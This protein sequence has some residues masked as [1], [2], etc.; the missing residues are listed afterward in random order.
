MAASHGK[1]ISQIT[2]ELNGGPLEQARNVG[3]PSPTSGETI[4]LGESAPA[5]EMSGGYLHNRPPPASL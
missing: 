4:V 1:A 5:L 3:L 2:S